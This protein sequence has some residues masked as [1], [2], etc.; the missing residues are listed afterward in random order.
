M[1]AENHG[2]AAS[3]QSENQ[4][5]H[6]TTANRV[7]ASGGL[8]END[9]VRIVDQ[10]L[11]EAD[12]ALHAFGKFSDHARSH[13][14]QSNHFQ[15]LFRTGFAFS[16]REMKKV[17]EEINRLAGIQIAVEIRFFRQITDARF[18]RDMSRRTTENFDVPLRRIQKSKQH[19]YG[20]RFAGTVWPEQS[21]NFS[22]PNFKIDVVHGARFGAAP[23]I[24]EDLAEAANDNDVFSRLRSAV[25]GLRSFDGGH[26]DQVR[27]LI[28]LPNKNNMA[29]ATNT[30]LPTTS[31]AGSRA[32]NM[33]ATATNPQMMKNPPMAAAK[34]PVFW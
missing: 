13:L 23:E 4:I 7:E 32:I 11:G 24:F 19:F 3:R 34:L 17:S 27:R 16:R 5:F 15:K 6:F 14:I 29:P 31:N 33:A 25:R 9:Q 12:A 8:I 22:A 21:K 20:G 18:R 2:L 30:K 28:F 1:A 10:R 26:C